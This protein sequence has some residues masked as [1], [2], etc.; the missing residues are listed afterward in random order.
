[1][2]SGNWLILGGV[3]YIGRNLC[4]FLLESNIA[5]HVTVADK[6][7]P[8]TSYFHPSHEALFASLELIQTD[9]SRNPAKAFNKEYRYI[10]NLCGETR[11]GLPESR[12]RQSSVGVVQAC[13]PFVGSA[14]WIEISSALVYKSNKKGASENDPLEPWTIEGRWR[15]EAERALAGINCVVLRVAR[16]YGCGD[17]STIT[18]RAIL[19][20]VY[21]RLKQKMKLLWGADLRIATIHVRDLCRAIVFLKD[22]EGVFNIS[23][24]A[25]TTQDDI[26][27]VIQAL[28]NVKADYYSRVI[29]NL[30]SLEAVAEE[31]N[32]MHMTPWAEICAEGGVDCPL[33]PYVE[34]EN[35]DGSHLAVTSSKLLSAGF[36]LEQPRLTPESVRQSLEFLIAG[37]VIPNILH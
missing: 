11:G 17:F 2:D 21:I 12:Y 22:A 10:V 3:G 33:Y 6:S 5:S 18:P 1:M 37:R 29:S 31:A 15:L 14:K 23:D 26:G 16:V 20:A 36:S 9:L 19:A 34:Q 8:A 30:A 27:R 13:R 24:N 7:I 35:L 32:S 25:Q 28:F 4:Q